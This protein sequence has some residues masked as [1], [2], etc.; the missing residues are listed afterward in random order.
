MT[1]PG[2]ARRALLDVNVLI[3]LLDQDH[4]GHQK[5]RGW[6]TREIGAGWASCAITQ[7]G[8]I[9]VV[10]QPRYPS[11]ISTTQAMVLL[12]NATSTEHHRFLP[13]DVSLLDSTAIEGDRVH[14]PKQ[15]TDAYLLALAVKHGGRLVTYDVAIPLSAVAGATADHLVVL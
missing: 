15:V 1:A 5:A 6:L 11:P 7:N 9:R 2:P 10:S 8:Y 3:A 14:G 13:C 12:R 4:V